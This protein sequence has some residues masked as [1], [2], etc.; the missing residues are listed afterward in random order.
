[1]IAVVY[2][3]RGSRSVDGGRLA[4]DLE[5]RIRCQQAKRE[6]ALLFLSDCKF[7]CVTFE[8]PGTQVFKKTSQSGKEKP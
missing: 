3:E 7:G 1:M 4:L 2:K 5:A 8:L 6:A